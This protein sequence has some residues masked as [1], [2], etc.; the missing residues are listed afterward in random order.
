MIKKYPPQIVESGVDINTIEFSSNSELVLR[1]E[2]PA[3]HRIMI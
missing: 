1:K 3:L 2:E